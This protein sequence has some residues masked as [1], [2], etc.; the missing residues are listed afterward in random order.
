MLGRHFSP[1]RPQTYNHRPNPSRGLRW[2]RAITVKNLYEVL[3]VSKDA[4]AADIKSAYRK[5]AKT[6][7]PDLNP[8]DANAEA[9]FKEVAAAFDILGDAEKRAKYDRGE[10]DAEGQERPQQQYY[11][12]YAGQDGA[13]RLIGGCRPFII[14]FA[15]TTT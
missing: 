3:G 6:L 14:R 12:N 1:S 5:L 11:R 8:S 10:I 2:N 13:I 4:S 9:R 7:H 15:Q